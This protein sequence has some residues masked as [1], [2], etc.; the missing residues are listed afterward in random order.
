VVWCVSREWCVIHWMLSTYNF[1]WLS[2]PGKWWLIGWAP[3]KRTM[4]L[5]EKMKFPA[6][7]GSGH[8]SFF[9]SGQLFFIGSQQ[10]RSRCQPT[11]VVWYQTSSAGQTR[12]NKY[13]LHCIPFSLSN[14]VTS[15][16]GR[17]V[18]NRG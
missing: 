1:Y 4:P 18:V 13:I 12:K 11:A 5:E 15:S 3:K 6:G 10:Y 17:T 8:F 16:A 9:L 7:I 14:S 2:L